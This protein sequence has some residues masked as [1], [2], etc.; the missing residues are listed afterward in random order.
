MLT[1]VLLL[2][3]GTPQIGDVE[4]VD[5]SSAGLFS[6]ALRSSDGPLGPYVAGATVYLDVEDGFA[7]QYDQAGWVLTSPDTDLVTIHNAYTTI[8]G[9]DG[10]SYQRLDAFVETKGEGIARLEVLDP[11]GEVLLTAELDA[12]HP[13]AFEATART[14][15]MVDREDLDDVDAVRQVVVRGEAAFGL[16]WLGDGEELYGHAS[17]ALTSVDNGTAEQ[18]RS[19]AFGDDRDWILVQPAEAGPMTVTFET[20]RGLQAGFEVEAVDQVDVVDVDLYSDG[21]AEAGEG[22]ELEVVAVG[23][24]S[25]G[26]AVHGIGPS[27]SWEG[28]ELGHGDIFRYEYAEDASALL[29]VRWN[30]FEREV[31]VRGIHP[32]V[33]RSSDIGCS[34]SGTAGLWLLGL[35]PL[36]VRRRR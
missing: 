20:D 11:R 13:D 7:T 32:E 17:Y 28:E 12:R 29:A 16:R 19:G 36:A 33:A 10:D 15:E 21:F 23:R 31:E 22:A 9:E 3:C 34:V 8:E 1:T 18:D 4:L 25:D 2:A 24:T 6:G 26:T 27:W 30:D 14:F 5:R 35:L